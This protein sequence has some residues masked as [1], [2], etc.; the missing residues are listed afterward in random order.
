[1]NAIRHLIWGSGLLLVI[2]FPLYYQYYNYT[3]NIMDTSA[4]ALFL[5]F[6]VII[7]AIEL[8]VEHIFDEDG[9]YE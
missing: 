3:H 1:M 5:M 6:G 9:Y 2:G 7:L 8:N 4:S